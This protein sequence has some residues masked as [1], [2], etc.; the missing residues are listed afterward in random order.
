MSDD[1][2]A[3]ASFILAAEFTPE[4]P[5]SRA[6]L[7]YSNSTDVT[8][9]HVS[10]QTELYSQEQWV[11]LDYHEADIVA[12]PAYTTRTI[13][14]GQPP[15]PF[16]ISAFCAGAPPADG[17]PDVGGDNAPITAIDW[18]GGPALLRGSADG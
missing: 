10:D 16:A 1:I 7:A 15:P 12:D 8:S 3:G 6:I 2:T 17:F 11:A 13:R 18:L 5:R 4:G 14:Q 9:P